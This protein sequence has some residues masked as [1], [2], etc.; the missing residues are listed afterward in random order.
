MF[1][2]GSIVL[3]GVVVDQAQLTGIRNENLMAKAGEQRAD[4]TGVSADLHRH[5]ARGKGGELAFESGGRHGDAAL[6]DHLTSWIQNT[7][8][9]AFVSKIYAHENG[10][11]FEQ[12]RVLLLLAPRHLECAECW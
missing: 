1:G 12:G 10:G 2:I 3:A 9:G 7:E 8:V 4:P 11:I 5:P 6:F